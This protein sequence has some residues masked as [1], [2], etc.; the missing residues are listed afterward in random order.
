[1]FSLLMFS[2]NF[3]SPLSS[4]KT[5]GRHSGKLVHQPSGP[6]FPLSTCGPPMRRH[7]YGNSLT[8]AALLWTAEWAL[9]QKSNEWAAQSWDV[10]CCS[11]AQ[12]LVLWVQWCPHMAHAK[13]LA[14]ARQ[15]ISWWCRQL[16]HLGHGELAK[17]WPEGH[18]ICCVTADPLWFR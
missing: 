17:W 5:S 4:D 14:R 18:L 15:D 7:L 1:M 10:L 13:L 8:L 3:S 9:L 12:W 16:C 6:S 11:G 2:W